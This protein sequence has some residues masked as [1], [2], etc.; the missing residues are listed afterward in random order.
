MRLTNL[1]LGFA[2][3]LL[4]AAG[5]AKGHESFD[6][7]AGP[8]VDAAVTADASCA[9]N[10]DSDGDGVPDQN[11]QCPN[12]PKGQPVNQVGCADS[13]LTPVLNPNFPPYGLTFSP[14]GD[15][16]RAG[17]LV[18]SYSGITRGDLFHIYWVVCDDPTTPCGM[19][20]AG[21]IDTAAQWTLDITNTDLPNGKLVFTN[22]THVVLADGT[23]PTLNG[24]QTI[25]IIDPASNN[26]AIPFANVI[27]LM[28][29]PRKAQFGAE[30][31]GTDFQVNVLTEIQD[32]ASGTWTPY[33]DWY[34]NA[35]APDDAGMAATYSLD[36]E[37]YDK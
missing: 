13:Q 10:C 32:P 33:L 28:I 34:D 8:G 36:G 2:P 20:L 23:N 24:R 9:P 35:H 25:T 15:P 5:C 14:S 12:T 31:T 17:G 21:A 3:A 7:P 6:A 16:G 18:W 30:I 27:T 11:D 37:F 4:L 29:P 19:S 26:T 22:M 1:V